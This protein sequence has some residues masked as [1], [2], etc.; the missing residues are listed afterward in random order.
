MRKENI[1]RAQVDKNLIQKTK[2]YFVG[3]VV[4]KDITKKIKS[5]ENKVYHVLFKKGAKTKLHHHQAGQILIPTN[6]IGVLVT[7]DRL[8]RSDGIKIKKIQETRLAKGDVV[9]IPKGRLHWHGAVGSTDFSHIAIN[10]NPNVHKESKTTWYESDFK[11]F[12]NKI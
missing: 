1:N 10:A 9:Y 3:N 8:K 7:Y 2:N 12:A 11:T 5:K 6:G 4:I